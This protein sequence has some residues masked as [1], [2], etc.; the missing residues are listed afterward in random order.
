[1]QAVARLRHPN[2][3]RMLPLPGGA[4]LS[5]VVGSARRLA[6]FTLPAGTFKRFDLEQVVRLLLDVLS[7]LSA[8]HEVV[9]DGQAF[10]HGEVSP[11]HIYIDEHGTARLVPLMNAHLTYAARLEDAG[12][13]APERLSGGVMDARSDVFSVGVM[14][15]EALAGKRL[16]S[17]ASLEGLMA[18]SSGTKPPR[19]RLA[20][21]LGW[22]E[23]LCAIA[24]RAVAS[25]PAKRFQT[26]LELSNAM[27]AAAAPQLSSVDTNAWQEEAPTPVFQ[28]KLHLKT[29]RNST[30]PPAVLTITGTMTGSDVPVVT[31]TVVRPLE[32]EVDAELVDFSPRLGKTR[33]ALLGA[34]ALAVAVG[35]FAWQK[36][37]R[38][39]GAWGASQAA[40]V[41]AA[42]EPG[43]S[44]VTEPSGPE[45]VH[46]AAPESEAPAA[47]APLVPPAPS[48]NLV[49]EAAPPVTAPARAVAVSASRPTKT[50]SAPKAPAAVKAKAKS[51]DGSND[52]GI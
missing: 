42:A 9:T 50:P 41:S 1:V 34:A 21:K 26:A 18:R 3:V 14:L 44:L 2:L 10:V 49:P 30:P 20:P 11:H 29:L 32:A 36:P 4:G 23:P 47:A 24:E 40:P 31:E 17:E 27:A 5:P 38:L 33:I 7:G 25:E 28:P 48:S 6:D 46:A 52:Y 15:W 16:Y 39:D 12:Y 43:L 45:P 51:R 19:I 13:A 35:F 8:L 37:H 22:A